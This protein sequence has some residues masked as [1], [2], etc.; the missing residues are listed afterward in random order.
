MVLKMKIAKYKGLSYHINKEMNSNKIF[1]IK[2]VKIMIQKL[3]MKT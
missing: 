1:S 2:C 3:K